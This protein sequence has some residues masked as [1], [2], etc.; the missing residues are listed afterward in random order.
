MTGPMAW[1]P[2][3]GQL[4]TTRRPAAGSFR[5][6]PLLLALP[7]PFYQRLMPFLVLPQPVDVLLSA[8]EQRTAFPL[9]FH[10]RPSPLKTVP[11]IAACPSCCLRQ[12]LLL[13]SVCPSA[14][15]ALHCGLDHP[16]PRRRSDL[17]PR[18][19][20]P[21]RVPSGC[22]R[23]QRAHAAAAGRQRPLPQALLPLTPGGCRRSQAAQHGGR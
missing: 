4:A 21:S 8:G 20:A 16:T 17:H 22:D 15:P 6:A 3:A 14:R 19:R 9:C 13:P 1:R 5:E 11:F 23:R 12:R 18:R 7:L 2:A 10:C